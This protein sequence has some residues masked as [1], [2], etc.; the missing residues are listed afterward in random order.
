MSTDDDERSPRV[1]VDVPED[2]SLDDALQQR[3]STPDD[4]QPRCPEC[5]S[6]QVM[7]RVHE[8][9]KDDVKPLEKGEGRGGYAEHPEPYRCDNCD[10]RFEEPL[11]PLAEVAEE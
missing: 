7:R 4:E 5:E 8:K 10:A 6:V 1:D 9:A 3:S 2:F 11:P